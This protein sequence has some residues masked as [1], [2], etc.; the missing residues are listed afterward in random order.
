LK[1]LAKYEVLGELGHG[2][3]GV[4]YRAHDPVINRPVALK[5]ITTG[6]ADDP[7]MLQRFYREAQSAGG[8]QHPN[9][10]TIYDM[11]EA[12]A[13]PYIA[14]ELV[15]GENLDQVIARRSS[16]P[17][18]LRLS[19]IMQACRA[20]DYAHKRGI[21]HRDIKPGNVMVSKDGIVKVVDFGI[22]RVLETS[23]TMTG[24][25]IGT[26]AYMSPEQYHG[27]HADE[28]SDIW[29]FG[30]LAYELLAYQ[31]P[32]TGPTPASLMH[33]IC[34]EDPTPLSKVLPD[35]PKELEA[36]VCKMLQKSPQQ[37][38]QSMEEVLLDLDPVRKAL[39]LQSINDLLEQSRQL[40][41]QEKFAESRELVREILQLESGNQEA[42]SLL[43]KTNLALRRIQNRPKAQQFVEKG[44]NLLGEG[45]LEEAKLAV[46]NALQLDSN[47][48]AAGQLQRVIQKELDRV[49]MV[50]SLL[51]SAKQHLAEG[52]PEEAEN[53]LGKLLEADPS[54]AH[55][56]NLLQQVQKE[57]FEREKGRRLLGGLQ[58][59]R[60]LWTRQNYSECLQLLQALEQEF[61]GEEEVL[62]LRDTVRE[63]QLEQAKQ[64]MLLQSRNL[65][66][67]G[68]HDSA[69][70]LL[71]DL[72]K[73]FPS[74]EEIPEVL[75][76]VRK[77]QL[78]QQRLAGISEMRNLLATGQYD[79]CIALA[80]DLR[81]TFPDEPEIA[82]LLDT[83]Q[84]NKTEQ[85]RLRGITEA[86]K[87]LATRQHN[88]CLAFLAKLAK[89]FPGDEE[90]LALQKVVGED[91]AEFEKQQ[92][93][94]EARGLFTSR[95]YD[96][97]LERLAALEKRF[98]GE[99]EIQRLQN[100]VREDRA[101]QRRLQA[102]EQAR[103]FL[104]SKNY[105]QC[106]ALLVSLQQEFPDDDETRMLLEA[107]RRE[108][109]EQRRR[110]VLGQARTLAGARRYDEAIAQLTKL[111]GA[112]PSDAGIGKLLESYRKEQAEQKQREGLAQARGLVAA[113]RYEESIAF[114]TKLQAEFPGEG[115][116]VKLLDSTRKEQAEQRQREG[117]T[118]A[119]N[120][121]GAGHYEESI[122]LLRELQADF[123]GESEI[124]KLL[125]TARE[126][127]AEQQKQEKLAD[128]RSLLAA[129]SF[130]N[131][132]EILN[133]L[134]AA[135]PK[136]SA[137]VKLRTLVER[138][139][140]KHV[141][142]AK[143][144]NELGVLKKLMG[145]K[146]YP[147]VMTR[148]NQLL[149]EFPGEPNVARLAEFAANRQAS[150]E[151]ELLLKQ[152]L[153]EVKA[154]FGAS[155][156]QD[157]MRV[158][159]NALKSFPGNAE[160]Q[161]LYQQSESGQKKLQVRQQI[162]Q[163]VREIKVK[164]N[165]EELSDAVALARETLVTLGPD[166]NLTHLLNSA[167]VEMEARE[168]KRSQEGA[169]ETIRTQIDSGDLDAASR[170]IE[171]VIE[172]NTLESYD[173]R[174]QRLSERIKD[175]KS[176]PAGEPAAP[177][178]PGLSKEYALATP[179]P[180]A[181]P[182]PEKAPPVDWTATA[183][184]SAST[185]A[186]PERPA[187]AKPSETLAPRA[188]EAGVQLPADAPVTEP[189]VEPRTPVVPPPA[190]T[191][192]VAAPTSV[193]PRP[194]PRRTV[195]APWLKAAAGVIVIAL[196]AGVWFAWRSRSGSTTTRKGP[197]AKLAPQRS[198]PPP[199]D[200]LEA[201][202]RQALDDANAKIAA[203]DLDGAMQELKQ[204]EQLNGPL[205]LQIQKTLTEV[206]ESKNNA[207]VAELRR[208]EADLWQKA[209][210]NVETGQYGPAEKE[211][212]QILTLGPEG[213]RKLEARTYLDKTIPQ[214]KRNDELLAEARRRL[215]QRDYAAARGYADQLEQNA[216]DPRALDGEIDRLESSEL[217]QLKSQFE[218]AK[219][220]EDQS[221]LTQLD[222][223]QRSLQ[224]LAQDQR[225]QQAHE[226]QTYL[227]NI[228][229]ATN[230]VRGRMDKK[231]ADQKEQAA[232]V[233]RQKLE[234][235]FQQVVQGYRQ[236]AQDQNGL[237]AARNSFQKIADNDPSHAEGA[238]RF[239]SEIDNKLA[240][241]NKPAQPLLPS[242]AEIAAADDKAIRGVVQSYFN[243][244]QQRN[245]DGLKQLWP[246]MPQK[247]Y[248]AYKGSFVQ[249]SSAT[250]TPVSWDVKRSP[251]GATATVSVQS[252]LV[253]VPKN[254]SK[255]TRTA[256]PWAFQLVKRNGAWSLTDVR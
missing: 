6:V 51:E 167:Q 166:T 54:N 192:P 94:E 188:P 1:K 85:A 47:F 190:V 63:D 79:A 226:A 194:A 96:P 152:K 46:E 168:K 11:G 164:I 162:E 123:P 181:P 2:A 238:R 53:L 61:P 172:S 224:K 215:A 114:L 214:R 93:L 240:E 75:E 253:E 106:V 254:G 149:K 244:F 7:A 227:D 55:A 245:A 113:C 115:S 185:T 100:A 45:K 84:Q 231:T 90:I 165:R 66:A 247:M 249:L 9:I 86:G 196:V 13:L 60:E 169:L 228:G 135:H 225:F 50:G 235:V 73:Q 252:E 140:E 236:G 111:Q 256:A 251:D 250:I 18:T 108:Q 174:I 107:A 146:K 52:L 195:R 163:R 183:Q 219:Q 189:N 14:M 118:I 127:L 42:R 248:D 39:Q 99:V 32:F 243:A 67:S 143:I 154:F 207:T 70:A 177:G 95:K 178:V 28:R 40:F 21:V 206:E 208:H 88:E 25:L 87:L 49:R 242:P 120:L 153:D 104:A 44:Q 38:Y 3:M 68:R 223:L 81:K 121:L 159:Q 186:I 200:P 171:K 77:D 27:E 125:V 103:S 199:V 148:A 176:A 58:Q 151:Q 182:A 122:T 12:G 102:V 78:N 142:A 141:K 74:D 109:A 230:T 97:C 144:Q 110:E 82:R 71:S 155:R 218:Q 233:E 57:K 65:L 229:G 16:L 130:D 147:E 212:R 83:A 150:I 48:T 30:V 43:E 211:L 124:S 187:P 10:V 216:G 156:F 241:L 180:E 105:E 41:A 221:A 220:G 246:T 129:Q 128:A 222:G 136:D 62:R 112:F 137:V 23:R 145:D 213:V 37:R 56:Q 20:L 255:E 191:R 91:Q 31:R 160:L 204:A 209:V 197:T 201:K 29:S 139:Q 19:Y 198:Q 173:P 202:Q 80:A 4:V 15:E 26:F 59:A 205:T 232:A 175:A 69:I 117:L 234:A 33:N 24:L 217:Q 17:L 89:Q 170:S 193:E 8:L 72:Q 203:N 35:F 210:R 92:A 157:A 237:T 184:F 179:I 133:S 126:D 101:K 116:I 98:P 239:L 64:Q 36:V 76:D 5:T 119:R 131:A 132:L 158:A 34:S 134:V 22:A 161:S 138:E